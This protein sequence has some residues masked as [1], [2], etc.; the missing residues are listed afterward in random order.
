MASGA[1]IGPLRVVQQFLS[2]MDK[3][4]MKLILNI[5]SEAGSI[6][7]SKREN[8]F[9]YCMSKAALN[10]QSKILHN[11]LQPRGFIVLIVH[12]GWMRTNM[13]GPSAAINSDESAAGIFDLAAREPKPGDPIYIDYRGEPLPW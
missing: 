4:E 8:Q 9:V 12:P 3:G 6:A 2:L 7:D 11:Y 1:V 5:S 10:M 13:G